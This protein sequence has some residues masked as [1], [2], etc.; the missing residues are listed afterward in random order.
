MKAALVFVAFVGAV[1]AEPQISNEWSAFVAN[2]LVQ[3]QG[4]VLCVALHG[5]S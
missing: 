2:D 5:W 3:N 1:V 4:C